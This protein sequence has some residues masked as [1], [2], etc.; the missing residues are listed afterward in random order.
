MGSNFAKFL[1]WL[2]LV[3]NGI[4]LRKGG[5]SIVLAWSYGTHYLEPREGAGAKSKL[6]V[7]S[8]SGRATCGF[9]PKNWTRGMSVKAAQTRGVMLQWVHDQA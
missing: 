8:F 4:F 5:T 3:G 6:V 9:Q 2:S 1:P 7:E